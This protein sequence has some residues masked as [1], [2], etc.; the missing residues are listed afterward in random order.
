MSAGGFRVLLAYL[1][2][3]K[4]PQEEEWVP[5]SMELA[6]MADLFQVE[7][8]FQHFVRSFRNGLAVDNIIG[9]LVE[10]HDSNLAALENAAMD[11]LRANALAFQVPPKC[12]CAWS[13][14][15]DLVTCY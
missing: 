6:Q 9:R 12:L 2:A 10:A 14:R 3:G 11:Y 15:D 4:V 7:G 8:L 1:Y 13:L 5:G